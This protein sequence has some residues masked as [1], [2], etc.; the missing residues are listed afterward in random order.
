MDTI[1]KLVVFFIEF[2]FIVLL[3]R[4]LMPALIGVQPTLLESLLIGALGELP[5]IYLLHQKWIK[6]S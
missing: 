1:G 5:L 3:V 6:R 4:Q 2:L